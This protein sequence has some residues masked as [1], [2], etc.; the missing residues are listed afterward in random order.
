MAGFVAQ[1]STFSFAPAA[2]SSVVLTATRVAVEEPTAE[3]VNMTSALSTVTA[4]MNLV[5]TGDWVSHGAVSVD[6]I[7]APSMTTLKG[8]IGKSG[9]LSFTGS[10]FTFSTKAIAE[11]GEITAGVG[12]VVSGRALFRITT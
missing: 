4:A 3:Y 5:P 1:G 8:I 9:T 6:F 11:S 12:E 2:G 7:C 10:S